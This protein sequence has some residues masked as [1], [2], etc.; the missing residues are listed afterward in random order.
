MERGRERVSRHICIIDN[1]ADFADLLADVLTADADCSVRAYTQA[2]DTDELVAARPDL[3][4]LDLR[5]GAMD[6]FDGW[7]ALQAIRARAELSDLPVILCSG[8]VLTLEEYDERLRADSRVVV[9][10]KPFGLD[11]LLRALAWAGGDRSYQPAAV[12]AAPPA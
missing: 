7:A 1:D 8:D 11:E 9:L 6:G 5:L 4:V 2:P 3:L 10:H 12:T